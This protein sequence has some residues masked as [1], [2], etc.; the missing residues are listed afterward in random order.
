MLVWQALAVIG[1][2]H[3]GTIH[4]SL[5]RSDIPDGVRLIIWDDEEPAGM[6][7]S[8][9]HLRAAMDG[10]GKEVGEGNVKMYLLGTELLG[11]TL[12][13]RALLVTSTAPLV[14]ALAS[15]PE[16]DSEALLDGALLELLNRAEEER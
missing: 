11:I 5:G 8:R 2:G 7:I 4:I 3:I 14:K 9:E 1:D 6:D 16:V 10:G 12:I 13:D 15:V